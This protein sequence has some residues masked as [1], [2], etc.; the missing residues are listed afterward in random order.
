MIWHLEPLRHWYYL[1]HP[2][3]FVVRTNCFL[4]KECPHASVFH[5]PNFEKLGRLIRGP[6]NLRQFTFVLLKNI[7]G[8][9]DIFWLWQNF[10]P[11]VVVSSQDPQIFQSPEAECR[12]EPWFIARTNGIIEGLHLDYP[13]FSC[14]FCRMRTMLL[15]CQSFSKVSF[16]FIN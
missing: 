15:D 13:R 16:S 7:A 9:L 6:W 14:R 1:A 11:R 10:Y 3:T 5:R 4:T 12:E 2:I 8:G